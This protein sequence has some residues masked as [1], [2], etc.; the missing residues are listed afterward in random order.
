[1]RHKGSGARAPRHED[2]RDTGALAGEPAHGPGIQGLEG[3]AGGSE[4]SAPPPR[5]ERGRGRRAFAYDLIERWYCMTASG[6]QTTT[7]PTAQISV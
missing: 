6:A 3:G 2:A 7:I 1:M 4:R 5:R